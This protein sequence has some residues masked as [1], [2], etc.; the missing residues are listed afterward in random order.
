MLT[1]E[2]LCRVLLPKLQLPRNLERLHLG[3]DMWYEEEDAYHVLTNKAL[4]RNL[5]R[6]HLGPV[7]V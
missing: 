5:E 3:R 2:A 7:R 6:L 1:D 4:S